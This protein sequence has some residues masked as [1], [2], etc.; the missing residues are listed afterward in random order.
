[1]LPISVTVQLDAADDNGICESQTPA[2]AGD[3]DLDG[4][5]VSDGVAILA[6]PGSARQILVTTADDESGTTYVIYGTD[7]NGNEISEQMIGPDTTTDTTTQFFRTVTRIS[8]SGSAAGAI[9]IGTNG[10]GGSRIV[11]LDQWAGP[12]SLQVDV[13]GT[14]NFT[15]QS[16]NNNPNEVDPELITWVNFPSAALAAA[17]AS[18]QGSYSPSPGYLRLVINSGTGTVTM[19]VRQSL[20]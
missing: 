14:A 18:A 2:G 1:M 4:I 19:N 7:A 11:A 13:L 12:T 3:L 8:T 17:S 10:V 6:D 15:V 16:T 20:Y 5:L 9:I